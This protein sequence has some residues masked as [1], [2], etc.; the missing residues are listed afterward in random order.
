MNVDEII[1]E[2][3]ET[4]PPARYNEASLI[5][6]LEKRELGT[7]ATR[8]DIIS[9]LYDRKYISGNKIEVNQLG[10]N[11]FE[12]LHEYC[13]NLTSEELTR[14]LENK[15][16][17][18]DIDK[19]TKE[20]VIQEGR[21]E[22]SNI[23]KDIEKNK[24]EIGSNIY[25]AYQESKIICKCP[26]CDGNLVQR[27]S[28][29]NKQNFVGCSN[30]PDCKT[31][32]SLPKGARFLKQTCE[33]CGLPMISFGSKPPVHACLDPNCGKEKNRP[34]EPEMVGKCPQC[35]GNL[36]KRSGRFGEFIGCKSFPKCRFTCSV[37]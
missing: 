18:I 8:A 7:K 15:L 16:E 22:V 35:G 29:K 28:P 2:E 33:K 23:L 12:T 30:Y 21:E 37:E 36:I 26:N 27:Y 19:T 11:I 1:S 20:D 13:V 10:E 4:K 17:L 14:D 9:K 3:K 24:Q 32:F 6:E 5:K 25:D 34:T 31:T